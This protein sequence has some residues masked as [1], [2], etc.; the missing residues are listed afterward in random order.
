MRRIERMLER[1]RRG[2][3]GVLANLERCF[4][5]VGARLSRRTPKSRSSCPC[6]RSIRVIRL[7][8]P[9]LMLVSLA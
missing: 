1:L 5:V 6:I 7:G 2:A 9:F 4:W 3:R 8:P